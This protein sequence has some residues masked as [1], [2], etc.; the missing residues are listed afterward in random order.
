MAL[1]RA[2]SKRAELLADKER[3]LAVLSHSL[4]RTQKEVSDDGADAFLL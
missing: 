3:Q 2:K 1:H 4:T